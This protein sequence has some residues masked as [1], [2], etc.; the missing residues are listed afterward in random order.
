MR[1]VDMERSVKGNGERRIEEGV[2]GGGE[3]GRRGARAGGRKKIEEA[4]R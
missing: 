4:R 2:G 1:D 3:E